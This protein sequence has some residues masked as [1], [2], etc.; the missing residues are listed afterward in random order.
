MTILGL[1]F[2][3]TLIRNQPYSSFTDK[4]NCPEGTLSHLYFCKCF[5]SFDFIALLAPSSWL[6]HYKIS[7]N[8]YR[9]FEY[10]HTQTFAIVFPY[11]EN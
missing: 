8:K 6:P 3:Q 11:Y 5:R 1:I 2:I 7:L 4:E 9:P 10:F